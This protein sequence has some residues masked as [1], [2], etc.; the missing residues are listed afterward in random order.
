MIELIALWMLTHDPQDINYD[1]YV[2]QVNRRGFSCCNNNDWANPND[3]RRSASGYQVRIIDNWIDVPDF[4]VLQGRSP[5]GTSVVWFSSFEGK[6]TI[7][8]FIP[9]SEG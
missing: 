9:G 3:W 5:T 2:R 7:F 6:I 8:C 1:W 4:A